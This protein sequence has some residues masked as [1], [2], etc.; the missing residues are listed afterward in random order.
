[1]IHMDKIGQTCYLQAGYSVLKFRFI[2]PHRSFRLILTMR[3]PILQMILHRC[4]P[5]SHKDFP[6]LA[7]VKLLS[8]LHEAWSVLGAS[9]GFMKQP[10]PR[11]RSRTTGCQVWCA[12]HKAGACSCCSTTKGGC[13]KHTPL[14]SDEFAAT[15][16]LTESAGIHS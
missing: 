7:L 2:H 14:E 10:I 12:M 9:P 13:T 15:P 4:P 5:N 6:I 8:T 11:G 16:G 3:P 1:M